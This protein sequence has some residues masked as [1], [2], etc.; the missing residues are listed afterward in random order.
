MHGIVFDN[1]QNVV[2]Q[3]KNLCDDPVDRAMDFLHAHKKRLISVTSN[4]IE[5][6]EVNFH[7]RK[8]ERYVKLTEL[9]VI[10]ELRPDANLGGNA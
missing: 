4:C 7:M 5:L 9:R 6:K 8:I 1:L 2:R 10:L 3:L